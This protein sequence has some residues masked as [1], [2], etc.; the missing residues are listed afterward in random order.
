MKVGFGAAWWEARCEGSGCE[1]ATAPR[2]H[3]GTKVPFGE[4][5][6]S[7]GRG[8][9]SCGVLGTQH[10]ARLCLWHWC[11]DAPRRALCCRALTRSILCKSI[12]VVCC[13]NRGTLVTKYW[14]DVCKRLLSWLGSG[15]LGWH[16]EGAGGGSLGRVSGCFT[17]AGAAGAENSAVMKGAGSGRAMRA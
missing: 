14:C 12:Q 3:W 2:G 6:W 8:T 15:P 11:G 7:E 1:G 5:L 17:C 16:W 10:V 13:G 9:G 4:A